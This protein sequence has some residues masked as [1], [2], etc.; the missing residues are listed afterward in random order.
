MYQKCLTSTFISKKRKYS[1]LQSFTTGVG[2]KQ[3][4][5]GSQKRE[6]APN[7]TCIC[8]KVR[9]KTD[10]AEIKT[11]VTRQKHST[12]GDCYCFKLSKFDMEKIK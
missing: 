4:I 1:E 7:F 9:L 2:N 12:V 5:V 10:D 8:H 3:L 11:A 6:I